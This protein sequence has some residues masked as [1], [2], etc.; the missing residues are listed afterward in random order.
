MLG[1]EKRDTFNNCVL[2]VDEYFEIKISEKVEIDFITVIANSHYK[3]TLFVEYINFFLE[4][5]F[6]IIWPADHTS[7]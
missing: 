5:K 1:I 2:V 3:R 4:R 6:S 7:T